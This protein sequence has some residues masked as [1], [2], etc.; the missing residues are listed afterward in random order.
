M[1][2]KENLCKTIRE[3]KDFPIKG[4][5]FRDI[6]PI[7]KD[8]AL[9]NQTISFLSDKFKDYKLD[10]IA[11]I[12]SRGFLFGMPLAVKLNI[13]FVPIRKKGKLP[14]Q[15]VQ[16]A[17]ALEYGAA[18]IEMHKDAL[19]KGERVL[20]IDDLLATGGTIN[21]SVELVEKL[22]AKPIAAAFVIELADLN[23]R[24]SIK[25]KELEVLSILQYK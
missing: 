7:L 6:T 19:N 17:Y 15:T 21:A 25:N 18:V 22:G 14:A 12:E 10:K 13:P 5:V 2:F 24:K 4:I 23:G 20:I 8:V 3:I 1:D 9:F 16:A 11:A